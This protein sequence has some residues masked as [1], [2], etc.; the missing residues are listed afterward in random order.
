MFVDDCDLWTS[1][2]PDATEADLIHTFGKAAQAWE[3][4]LFTSG[5]LLALHK[6]YWWLIAWDWNQGLPRPRF[7]SMDSHEIVLSNGTDD[8]PIAIKRLELDEANVGLGLRLSPSGDQAQ[9]IA[10]RHRQV[11]LI[12]HRSS[13][14]ILSASEAWIFYTS[15]FIPKIFNP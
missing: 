9:E 13:P 7:I 5:G 12:A 1:L 15:I 6:C 11:S 8:V 4:L 14:L 3:R 2:P 10:F